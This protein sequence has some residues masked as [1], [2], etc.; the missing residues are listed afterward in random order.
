MA[1]EKPEPGAGAGRREPIKLDSAARHLLEE[2]R[3]VL[4]GIQALFGF[5][6]IAVFSDG[7]ARLAHTEQ[8]AHLASILLVTVSIALIMAPAAYDRIVDDPMISRGFIRLASRVIT[9]AMVPL[10]LG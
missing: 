4:P 6:L 2:C 1:I 5:Q 3:M 7:F 10:M 8:L 9:S